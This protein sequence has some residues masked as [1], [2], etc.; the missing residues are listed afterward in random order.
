VTV[1]ETTDQP[2]DSALTFESADYAIP[3][4]QLGMFG[5]EQILVKKHVLPPGV[6][7]THGALLHDSESGHQYFLTLSELAQYQHPSADL[8]KIPDV[9]DG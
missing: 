7:V 2:K 4:D 5:I 8:P 3:R 9:L 1:T 6:Q